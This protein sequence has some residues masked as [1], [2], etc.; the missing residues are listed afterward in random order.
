MVALAAAAL[1]LVLTDVQTLPLSRPTLER[2]VAAALA[3]SDLDLSWD[4]APPRAGRPSSDGEVR[5]ILLDAHP[6]RVRELVLGAVLRGRTNTD[7]LWVYV[8]SIRRVLEGTEPGASNEL[9]LSIA[10]GRVI[11]HEIAHLVA[12]RRPH[13]GEGLMS[14]SVDRHI[15]LQAE[16]PLDADCRAAIRSAVAIGLAPVLKSGIGSA[17][18]IRGTADIGITSLKR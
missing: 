14:R 7:A 9:Q 16:T 13:A 10:V 11:A 8:G 1:T 15:L 3:D 2:A 6:Q 4:A 17:F 5:V 18:T 12:P